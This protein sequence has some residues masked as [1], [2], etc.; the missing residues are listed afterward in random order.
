MLVVNNILNYHS[1]FM[2]N[3][4]DIQLKQA[5]TKM[6]P[7]IVH[8]RYGSDLHWGTAD[9]PTWDNQCCVKEVLDTELLHLCWLVKKT[10]NDEQI[11]DFCD[12]TDDD[13]CLNW[14]DQ[15]IALAKVKGITIV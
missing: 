5:L 15:T 13:C 8:N 11:F 1:N 10:L 9:N 6:L 2:T 14:Q 12:I 4:T 7:D 3:Y